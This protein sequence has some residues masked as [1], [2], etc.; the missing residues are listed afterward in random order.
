MNIKKQVK[1]WGSSLHENISSLNNSKAFAGLIIIILNITSRHAGMKFSKNQEAFLKMN[2][3]RQLLIFSIAWMGTRDIFLA[4]II[5]VVF[6]VV[7]DYLLNEDS[8]FCV[9]P[10]KYKKLYDVMDTNNDGIIS[11][12]EI[13]DSIKVLQKAKKIK[14]GK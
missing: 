4:L 6:T 10:E 8:M 1:K 9:L 12:K 14:N 11:E 2:I 5:A 3:M 13:E 7:T